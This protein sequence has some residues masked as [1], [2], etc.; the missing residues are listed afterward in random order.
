MTDDQQRLGV[1]DDVKPHAYD[2]ETNPELFDGVLARRVIA[3]LIDLVIL[4]IPLVVLALFFFAVGIV[5]LGFGFVRPG[6]TAGASLS[7]GA[8]AQG[9]VAGKTTSINGASFILGPSIGVGL[10]EA[11][12]PLPYFTAAAALVCL[13]CYA[14]IRFRAASTPAG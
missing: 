10:Y 6:F 11:W 3:F 4:A 13:L 14:I 1:S 12:R 5:T 9:S 2:P 7:V 8:A